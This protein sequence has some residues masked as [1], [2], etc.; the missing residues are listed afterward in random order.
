LLVRAGQTMQPTRLA[1]RIAA[2]V[3]KGIAHLQ[4]ALNQR[5]DFDPAQGS[6]RFVIAMT[7]VGEVHFMPRL[8]ACCIQ[9]APN[10]RLEVSRAAGP[11]L[12]E[13]L[14]G[15][16]IDLALGPYSDLPDGFLQRRLFKQPCVSLFRASHP[17]AERPPSSLAGWRDARHLLVSNLASPYVEIRQRMEKAGIRFSAHD[18]VS[19]FLAAPFVVAASDCVVTV[20]SKLAEQFMAPLDLRGMRPPLRLPELATQMFWHRRNQG[21]P[22]QTWLRRVIV[23][24]FAE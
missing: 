17:F 1:E 11:A 16:D 23:M 9:Q 4:V 8:L 22:G 3:D 20:P 13:G 10:V 5:D 14:Q 6:R 15:G 21:D 7:D 12:R 18:Q 2:D 24:L 19:S